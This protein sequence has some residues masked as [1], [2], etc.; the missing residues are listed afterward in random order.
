MEIIFSF[1]PFKNYKILIKQ[2]IFFYKKFFLCD[3]FMQRDP[4]DQF[5]KDPDNAAKAYLLFQ[6][7]QIATTVI[8]VI[9]TIIFILYLCGVF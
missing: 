1:P 6:G 9:G 7:I 5:F 2:T 3:Y 8:I 4:I